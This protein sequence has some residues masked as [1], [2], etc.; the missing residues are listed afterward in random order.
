MAEFIDVLQTLF[1]RYGYTPGQAAKLANLPKNTLVNWLTGRVQKPRDWQPVVQL[2]RA[3]RL[4]KTETEE[5]LDAAGHPPLAD[6]AHLAPQHQAELS[7]WL[8]AAAPPAVVHAPFQAPPDLPYFVGRANLLQQLQQQLSAPHHTHL[9]LL[10]GPGGVGKTALATRLTYLCRPLFPDGVLW[11]NLAQADPMGILSS[12]AEAVGHNVTH[13]QTLEDR[14]RVVRGLLAH[15]R[16]LLLFD[17]VQ[18]GR[19]LPTLLPPSGPCAVLVLARRPLWSLPAGVKFWSIAPF[20]PAEKA[21]THLLAQLRAEP[22]TAEEEQLA[23]QLAHLVGQLPLALT[24]TLQRCVAE[25]WPLANLIAQMQETS[26]RWALVQDE[27]GRVF[28]AVAGGYA[29]LTAEQQTWVAPLAWLGR[30]AVPAELVIRL[31]GLSASEGLAWVRQ[32]VH[33]GLLHHSSPAGWYTIH[34]LVQDFLALQPQAPAGWE[35][36]YRYWLEEVAQGS[37]GYI[38]EIHPHLLALLRVANRDKVWQT[39]GLTLLEQVWGVWFA[40]GW[41]TTAGE[42]AQMA[43]E[44]SKDDPAGAGQWVLRLAQLARSQ[45][46][47]GKA[48]SYLSQAEPLLSHHPAGRVAWLTER[49]VYEACQWR[50]ELAHFYF[51]QALQLAREQHLTLALPKLLEELGIMAIQEDDYQT[52]EKLYQEGWQLVQQ[53]PHPA[54]L[55]VLSKSLGAWHLLQEEYGTAEQILRRGYVV[56]R[57]RKSVVELLSLLTNLGAVALLQQ[58]WAEAQG[59]LEEALLYEAQCTSGRGRA[60]VWCNYGLWAWFT[61]REE[62]AQSA[63]SQAEVLA[64]E[65]GAEN[66]WQR[67]Q[68]LK[69]WWAEGGEKPAVYPVVVL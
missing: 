20:D 46:E 28:A 61:G 31:A 50:S 51:T 1:N 30:A 3:L 64:A 8:A 11:V 68:L 60:M 69:K 55:M 43:A 32:L 40:A 33:T 19:L 41:W 22:L 67:G 37:A 59:W 39:K 5:L 47:W 7:Y 65:S 45:Q 6:L 34:P 63:M 13:Y 57:Q 54:G 18:E 44:W 14:S 66:V 48:H 25:G 38:Q 15:K 42:G 4:T 58:Q 10:H 29:L 53:E 2:A 36:L 12:F 16:L 21:A 52:A 26:G 49:G 24:I 56:A 17:E 27:V 9:Y 35:L 23:E 62:L